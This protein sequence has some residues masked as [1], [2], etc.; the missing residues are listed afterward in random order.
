VGLDQLRSGELLRLAQL[1]I[2]PA[3]TAGTAN[4]SPSGAA[5]IRTRLREDRRRFSIPAWLQALN[6]GRSFVTTGPMLFA[7]INSERRQEVAVD[8]GSSAKRPPCAWNSS[9]TARSMPPSSPSPR[10]RLPLRASSSDESAASH[11]RGWPC[12]YSNQ[13]LV[14][15]S[16]SRT[17]SGVRRYPRKTSPPAEG[18]GGL[19]GLSGATGDGAQQVV[20]PTEAFTEYARP[21]R[22][23]ASSPLRRGQLRASR[24]PARINTA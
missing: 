9:S 5:R 15:A 2:P 8:A 22:F 3:A 11:P 10:R 13:D 6:H 1:R 4:R 17:E 12:E 23:T 16:A 24:S 14:I 19:S 18:R 7:E 20:L 21:S